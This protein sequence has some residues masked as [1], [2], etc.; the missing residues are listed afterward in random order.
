M[1][2]HRRGVLAALLLLTLASQA[3]AAVTY[4]ASASAVSSSATSIT[5]TSFNGGVGANRVLVVGLSFGQGA[6]AGVRVTFGGG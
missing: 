1:R 6:P 5:L 2:F 3:R 4:S